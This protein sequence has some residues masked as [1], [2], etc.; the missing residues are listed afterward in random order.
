[1]KWCSGRLAARQSQ[2][3]SD[4]HSRKSAFNLIYSTETHTLKKG[5]VL[6]SGDKGSKGVVQEMSMGYVAVY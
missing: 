3:Y 2:F 5:V 4:L 6:L 1:M